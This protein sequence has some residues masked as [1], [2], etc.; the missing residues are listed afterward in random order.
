MSVFNTPMKIQNSW[1][2]V[3]E[4]AVKRQVVTESVARTLTSMHA[5][6]QIRYVLDK[7]PLDD[8]DFINVPADA[9][10]LQQLGY[11]DAFPTPAFN[12]D[13]AEYN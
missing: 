12:R 9:D 5:M 4:E 10:E 3:L 1:F 8:M 2:L 6:V 7:L 13:D 11:R